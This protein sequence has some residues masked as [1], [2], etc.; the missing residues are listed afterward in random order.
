MGK[1]FAGFHSSGTMPS[2]TVSLK[3]IVITGAI[4]H[5][6]VLQNQYGKSSGPEA[7]LLCFNKSLYKQCQ[8]II[9]ILLCPLEY[10]EVAG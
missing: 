4:S 9:Q 6:Q 7:V 10:E 3:I 5:A 8:Q 1:R 2:L